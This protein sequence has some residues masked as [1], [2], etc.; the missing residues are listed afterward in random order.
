MYSWEIEEYLN[1]KNHKLT[2]TEF[3]DIINSSPQVKDVYYNKENKFKIKPDD[4]KGMEITL[5]EERSK[6]LKLTR[7]SDK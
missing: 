4:Y 5:I 6:S 1:K 7:K 3:V 2:P